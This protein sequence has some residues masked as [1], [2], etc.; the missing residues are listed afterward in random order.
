MPVA[1]AVRINGVLHD[2]QTDLSADSVF[3]VYS[4]TK[5]LIAICALRLVEAGS[6]R[7]DAPI[8]GWL[9][10]VDLPGTVTL[11]HLL[12]HTSG[13]RDYGLLPEYHQAVRRHAD[14][15][16]TREDFLDAVLPKGMLFAPGDNW[17]Y[18]NIGYMLVV[19]ILE[20]LT[21]LGI[22]A[23]L[24]ADSEGKPNGIPG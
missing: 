1:V 24:N 12:R 2:H 8:H 14:R 7:L 19:D 15:P 13:L 9:P 18:S 16:W 21:G 4:I 23:K 6:L 17:A 5:T 10:D 20:R 11:T 22:P 3:P